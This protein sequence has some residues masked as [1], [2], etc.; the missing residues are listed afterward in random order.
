MET[1]DIIQKTVDETVIKLKMAGL[2]REEQH[3]IYEKTEKLLKNYNELKKSDDDTA[4]KFVDKALTELYNDLYYDIIPMI[5]F[6][7][8]TREQVAE[9]FDVDVRTITRNK[10]RLIKKLSCILFS[11]DAIKELFF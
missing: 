6:E 1:I 9:Y 10:R 3:S 7:N 11:G 4:K 8:Q 5:Y 2:M